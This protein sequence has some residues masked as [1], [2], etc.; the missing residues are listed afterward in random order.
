MPRY[1]FHVE[2]GASHRDVEGLE[3][4][5]LDAAREHAVAQFADLL[6]CSARAFW[7]SGD[8]LMRVT[9]ETGLIFFTLHFAA[10]TAAAGGGA[11][12]A[13]SA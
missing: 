7:K 13:R 6:R 2:D 8:W 11:P 3:L 5:G 12:N 10:V 4:N 1:F 9:D